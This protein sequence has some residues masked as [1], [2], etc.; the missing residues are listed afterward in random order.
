MFNILEIDL[1]FGTV[2]KCSGDLIF[3]GFW[4]IEIAVND[5]GLVDDWEILV[6]EDPGSPFLP[7]RKWKAG[8][9]WRPLNGGSIS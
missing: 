5:D 4:E 7:N 2:R 9:T 6:T 1:K 3:F 8:A